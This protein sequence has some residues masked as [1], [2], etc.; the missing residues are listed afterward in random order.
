[1]LTHKTSQVDRSAEN[2]NKQNSLSFW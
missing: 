1:L 2:K